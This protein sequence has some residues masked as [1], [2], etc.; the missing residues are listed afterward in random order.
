MTHQAVLERINSTP[1]QAVRAEDITW[2]LT[3]PVCCTE[4]AKNF[5]RDAAKLAGFIRD[6]DDA[7]VPRLAYVFHNMFPCV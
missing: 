5:M 3:V 4:P 7:K 6:E 2:I 1:T